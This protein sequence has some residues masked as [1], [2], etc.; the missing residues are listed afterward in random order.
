MI[1]LELSVQVMSEIPALWPSKVNSNL[2]VVACQSLTVESFAKEESKK[3]FY[4]WV[5]FLQAEANHFPSGENLTE[6]TES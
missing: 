4:Y 5:Y 3:L 1:N 6:D 2:P